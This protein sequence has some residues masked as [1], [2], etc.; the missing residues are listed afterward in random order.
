MTASNE[1]PDEDGNLNNKPKH[2]LY[3]GDDEDTPQLWLG[4]T[5]GSSTYTFEESLNE[6]PY[7][8]SI[9]KKNLILSSTIT[10]R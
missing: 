8:K 6:P 3:I 2:L 4:R 1:P 7:T 9:R 5:I 10:Q